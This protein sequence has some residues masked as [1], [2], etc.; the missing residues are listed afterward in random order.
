M[1]RGEHVERHRDG[2]L[3]ARGPTLDGEPHGDWAWFRRDGTRL[4]S[5]TFDRGRQVGEWTTYDRAGEPYKVTRPGEA[6]TAA[7]GTAAGGRDGGGGAP[8]ADVVTASTPLRDPALRLGRPAVR[9]LEAAGVATLGQA[10]AARDA[11]LL[12][13]HGVGPKAVRLL[14]ERQG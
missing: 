8:A 7:R 6:G 14:R 2:S 12:A 9:A 10:W 13:L 4:R 11:D 5:G 1:A 3:R